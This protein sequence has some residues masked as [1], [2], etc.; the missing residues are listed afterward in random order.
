MKT[1][2]HRSNA[3]HIRL[4]KQQGAKQS[5]MPVDQQFLPT[6]NGDKCNIIITKHPIDTTSFVKKY[7]IMLGCNLKLDAIDQI[8]KLV[9]I[10]IQLYYKDSIKMIITIYSRTQYNWDAIGRITIGIDVY[11]TVIVMTSV[12]GILMKLSTLVLFSNASIVVFDGMKLKLDNLSEFK[13]RYG[14]TTSVTIIVNFNSI[15]STGVTATCCLAAICFM[16][17]VTSALTSI[18]IVSIE[19]DV[20]IVSMDQLILNLAVYLSIDE[21]GCHTQVLRNV[22][23]VF[24]FFSLRC[25]CLVF[26]VLFLGL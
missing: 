16:V 3:A 8:K 2:F 15:S 12:I 25:I 19:F 24:Y 13:C 6:D 26:L 22:C 17:Q 7:S 18:I 21:V 1:S 23:D 10:R 11:E 9:I 5:R 14:N 4:S 20:N